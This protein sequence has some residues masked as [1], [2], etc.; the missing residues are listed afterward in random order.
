VK[1]QVTSDSNIPSSDTLPTD[2]TGQQ[3]KGCV[4]ILDDDIDVLAANAR[5]LRVSGYKVLVSN[6]AETALEQLRNE[7]VDV[8]VTDL[9]MPVMDG[10]EFA[11]EARKYKP[12][13]PLLFFSAFGSVPDVV[14]AMQL[15][16]VDFLVKPVDP[17]I[18]LDRLH[19]ICG[20]HQA[21]GLQSRM[22]FDDTET[23]FRQRVLAYEKYLI[24]SSLQQHQG[25]V[26][27][28]LDEL[29]INRRT[30]NEKM[31]RL[32]IKRDRMR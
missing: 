15:G 30:L 3:N 27:A 16:A 9:R 2:A 10:L 1:A 21:A 19:D 13:L 17:E 18:L 26:S 7:T 11:R 12:L 28:V 14:S 31:A 22:A 6:T 25:R 5:F 29:N 4:V 23:P 32:G 20:V 8:V 24:E